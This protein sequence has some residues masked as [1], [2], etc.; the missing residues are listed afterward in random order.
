MG[1]GRPMV[2][3]RLSL[4]LVVPVPCIFLPLPFC[5]VFPNCWSVPG[6]G[7]EFSFLCAAYRY[8]FSC[9]SHVRFT[10]HSFFP[11][12]VA[13]R[14]HHYLKMVTTVAMFVFY[15]LLIASDNDKVF[16]VR[17]LPSDTFFSQL[18]SFNHF[19]YSCCYR[20]NTLAWTI[21]CHMRTRNYPISPT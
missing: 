20:M 9:G 14:V 11:S 10:Y 7:V 8:Y 15:G 1:L 17:F 16:S 5:A 13:F 21:C 18:S 19:F 6:G 2:V 12:L 3:F 4:L